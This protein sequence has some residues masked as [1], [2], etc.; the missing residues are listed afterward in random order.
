L[1]YETVL[2]SDYISI[3]LSCRVFSHDEMLYP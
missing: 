2:Q 1:S 3:T